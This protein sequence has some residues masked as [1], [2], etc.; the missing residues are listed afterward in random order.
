LISD[1]SAGIRDVQL[2]EACYRSVS[3]QKWITLDE[4]VN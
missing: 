3:E 4:V 1:L 2:V